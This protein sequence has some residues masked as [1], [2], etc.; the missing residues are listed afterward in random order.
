LFVALHCTS[1]LSGFFLFQSQQDL[2]LDDLDDS[3]DDQTKRSR[4]NK[5]LRSPDRSVWDTSSLFPGGGKNEI[6]KMFEKFK[7]RMAEEDD[8][9]VHSDDPQMPV[10][11]AVTGAVTD[12][13][14]SPGH[15][16]YS[17][18][19][20]GI[21]KA[22]T[23]SVDDVHGAVNVKDAKQD[24]EK[25]KHKHRKHKRD[26]EK[27]SRHGK[28]K[29]KLVAEPDSATV[30]AAGTQ[31]TTPLSDSSV[32]IATGRH[33]SSDVS[34]HS[35]SPSPATVQ[36]AESAELE[37]PAV[38]ASCHTN[39]VFSEAPGERITDEIVSVDLN[40]LNVSTAELIPLTPTRQV[41]CGSLLLVSFHF[42]KLYLTFINVIFL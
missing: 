28:S 10:K 26:K 11:S 42:H 18:L 35:I 39:V 5:R 36:M 19:I 4:F 15:S 21:N 9:G 6:E 22:Y 38:H 3:K 33:M 8:N 17:K 13:D 1:G 14:F 2:S 37:L 20:G 16:E 12:S 34:H 41:C 27:K 31:V 7:I 40:P 25:K 32:F 30:I 23:S 29:S 24:G